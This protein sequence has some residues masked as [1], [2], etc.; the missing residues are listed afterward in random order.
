METKFNK[1]EILETIMKNLDIT[2]TMYKNAEEKYKSLAKYLEGKGLKCDIYP[3]GSFSLGTVIKP[4]KEGKMKGYDLD[5]ICVVS[6]DENLPA[7]EFRENIWNIINQNK[8]YSEIIK[9]YNKCFTLEYSKINGI[10]FNIDVLPAKPSNNNFIFLTN[11]IDEKVEWFK[12]NPKDYSEWFKEINDRYPQAKMIN[13]SYYNKINENVEELPSLFDRTSLQRVIQFLKYN[14]DHFYFTIKK[15]NKKVISAIITTI[16]TK[17][18]EK[19]NYTYLNTIELLKYIIS[20]LCIYAEL[21][22]KENLDQRYGDKIV[23]K[24]TNCKW[25][26]FN[27][28]NPQDNLADSW[29]EDSEIPILFFKWI[30]EIK[31]EFLI[32]NE[33]EYLTNFSNIFG[34]ENLD[35]NVKQFLGTPESVTPIKPWRG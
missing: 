28:V 15:E 35:E 16:C 3:Q 22:S 32:E 29:N 30:E 27:P 12:S 2:P 21:I 18:A 26:I 10:D 4:L 25:E 1:N 5:F 13:E 6:N 34:M 7:K 33:K 19:T 14:R 11:K 24:K 9:E 8:N 20:D 17:I 23:I 31:K